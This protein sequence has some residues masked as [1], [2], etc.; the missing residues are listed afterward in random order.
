[1]HWKQLELRQVVSPASRIAPV[2]DVRVIAA[3]AVAEAAIPGEVG[4]GAEVPRDSVLS[5]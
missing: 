3:R 2:F 1:M 4:D 5:Q